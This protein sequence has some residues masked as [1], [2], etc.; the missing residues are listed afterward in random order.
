MED[1]GGGGWVELRIL[2]KAMPWEAERTGEGI[3][4]PGVLPQKSQGEYAQNPLGKPTGQMI[5]IEGQG[6]YKGPCLWGD[7]M[8]TARNCRMGVDLRAVQSR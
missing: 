5:L 3:S 6:C 8:F 7:A 1:S 2:C 4:D